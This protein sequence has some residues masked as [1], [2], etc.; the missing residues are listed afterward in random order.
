MALYSYFQP[1]GA[2]AV[3]DPSGPLSAHIRPAAMKDTN[4]AV[5]NVSQGSSKPGAKYAKCTPERKASIGEYTSL[6]RNRAAIHHFL[7]QL[8]CRNK[9]TLWLLKLIRL[10][11]WLSLC[12]KHVLEMLESTVFAFPLE[13]NLQRTIWNPSCGKRWSH[14]SVGRESI[15][16]RSSSERGL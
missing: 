7:K 5:R 14:L 1:S 2:G 8:E 11:S 4:K 13:L 10:A 12:G 16:M 6:H 3:P 9:P 15:W